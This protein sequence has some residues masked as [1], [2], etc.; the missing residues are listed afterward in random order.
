MRLSR[1]CILLFVLSLIVVQSALSCPVC[2]G[3]KSS[4]MQAGMN[5]AILAMLG[6][7]GVVL[8]LIVVFFLV[9]WRRFKRLQKEI[10]EAAYID[11]HGVLQTM[12]E[13]GVQEWNNI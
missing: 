7:T 3:D 2:F 1:S 13:K 12:N 5:S 10:S 6:I 9:M 4:S 11:E 8:A